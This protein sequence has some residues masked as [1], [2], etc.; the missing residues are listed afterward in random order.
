M[1]KITYLW[2]Q[3]FQSCKTTQIFRASISGYKAKNRTSEIIEINLQTWIFYKRKIFKGKFFN[4]TE[5]ITVP[6]HTIWKVKDANWG[7]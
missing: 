3:G 7:L 4:H 1:N 6:I 5:I 2:T